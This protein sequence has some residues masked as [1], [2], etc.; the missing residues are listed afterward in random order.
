MQDRLGAPAAPQPVPARSLPVIEF[1]FGTPYRVQH[2]A[3]GG[4]RAAHPISLIGPQTHRRVNLV[5]SGTPDAFAVIFEPGGL[6][7]LFSIPQ[8]AVTDQDVD[9]TAALGRALARIHERLGNV[10]A[11][12]ER[13]ELADQCLTGRRPDSAPA[14]AILG[15]ARELHLRNGCATVTNLASAAGLSVRQFERRFQQEIGISPKLYARIVRFE[16]AL[17]A[18]AASPQIRWTE[19]AHT[20]GYFDQM[21]MVH[22]FN[23]LSGESPSLMSDQMAMVVKPQVEV[24]G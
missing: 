17:H 16:A 6:S 20:F 1:T 14:S 24:T 7:A 21:H 15:A 5:L 18:K 8:E 3:S 11:F 10:S 19:I 2:L 4:A 9:A 12:E 22:D 13:V 23:R